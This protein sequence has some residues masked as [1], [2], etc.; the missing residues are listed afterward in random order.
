VAEGISAFQQGGL[1]LRVGDSY[2]RILRSDSAVLGDRL[3][4]SLVFGEKLL[5]SCL[6][7]VSSGSRADGIEDAV[8]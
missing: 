4:V 6:I 1:Y 5:A 2:I 7:T 3:F 8:P